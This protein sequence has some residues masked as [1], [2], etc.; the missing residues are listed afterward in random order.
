[1]KTEKDSLVFLR[2]LLPYILALSGILLI[3]WF[4]RRLMPDLNTTTIALSY[5]IVVL[6]AASYGGL[7]PGIFAS[8]TGMLCFNYFFLPPVG[9]LTIQDPQNWIALTAFLLTAFVASKLSS[10]AR[11][12]ALEAERHRQEEGNLYELSRAIILTPDPE[13]ATSTIARQ[14]LEIFHLNYCGIFLRKSEGAW[15]RLSVANELQP[16]SFEPSKDRMREAFLRENIQ[17]EVSKNEKRTSLYVPL[18]LGVKVIGVM[19][20]LAPQIDRTVVEA[21]AGLVALA[22][23]RARFLNE[24]SFTKALEQSD[25]LKSA[26]LASVSHDLRTPLTSIRAAVD[27]LMEENVQNNPETLREFQWIIREDVERLT[28]LVENLLEMARIESAGLQLS[29]QWESVSELFHNVLTRC[30]NSLKNHRVRIEADEELPLVKIDSRL[31][32]QVLTNL[33]ENAAKYSPDGT[34]ILLRARLEE[35]NLLIRVTDQGSGI[36][37]E[38]TARI[39]EKFYRLKEPGSRSGGTGMGLAIARGIVQAHGGT[40]WVESNPGKGA[41]FICKIPV[42]QRA[43]ILSV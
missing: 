17:A 5:L 26:I 20:F 40:I 33:I 2:M 35:D 6:L 13:V 19:V 3:V 21:I 38:E 16:D 7:G 34:E 27:S 11:L 14:V 22:L 36:P 30:A 10:A 1:M 31:L 24:L 25:E 43:Q 18:K 39:F 41:T 4:H 32:S 42:E 23:E 8:L 9:T 37:P 15:D 12:R 29:K 28:H